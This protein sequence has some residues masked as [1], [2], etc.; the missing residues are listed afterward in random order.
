MRKTDVLE[1]HRRDVAKNMQTDVAILVPRLS[2][3][4]LHLVC[5][6]GHDQILHQQQNAELRD[7]LY[8]PRCH[9]NR[10]IPL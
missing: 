5:I 6:T 2:N 7:E 8:A 4:S 3:G 9:P 10:G 1:A